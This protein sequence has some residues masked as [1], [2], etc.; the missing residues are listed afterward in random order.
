MSP[1]SRQ[2][3]RQQYKEAHGKSAETVDEYQELVN[4]AATIREVQRDLAT[5]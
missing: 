4:M 3:A 1:Y 2:V 5:Q